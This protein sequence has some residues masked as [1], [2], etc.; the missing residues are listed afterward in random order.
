MRAAISAT[1]HAARLAL[2]GAVAICAVCAAPASSAGTTEARLA[3]RAAVL[4]RASVTVLK[5]PSMVTVTA[6]DIARG[7]VDASDNA[8]VAILC[9]SPSGYLLEFAI[10][11]DFLWQVI[12]FSSANDMEAG[13]ARGTVL[14]RCMGMGLAKAVVNLRFRFVLTENAVT[15]TYSWPAPV[16]FAVVIVMAR[17]LAAH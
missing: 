9:N 14:R 17:S 6:A 16:G 12:A 15:G 4:K 3:V 13:Q 10:Q 2:C 8:Q 1:L 7:F 5:Q 11:G